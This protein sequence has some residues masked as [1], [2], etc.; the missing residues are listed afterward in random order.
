V[1]SQ[2]LSQSSSIVGVELVDPEITEQVRLEAKDAICDEEPVETRR[3][4]IEAQALP[5]FQPSAGRFSAKPEVLASQF[6][7]VTKS[8]QVVPCFKN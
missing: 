4:E 8:V 1:L 5:P 2:L 6:K 3:T 7:P